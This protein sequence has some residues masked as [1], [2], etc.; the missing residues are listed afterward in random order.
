M[1]DGQSIISIYYFHYQTSVLT[2]YKP[3]LVDTGVSVCASVCQS[4][5]IGPVADPQIS[6]GPTSIQRLNQVSKGLL[7]FS[8]EESPRTEIP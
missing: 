3:V 8:F 6:F 1:A 7:Q 2:R 4:R 5:G